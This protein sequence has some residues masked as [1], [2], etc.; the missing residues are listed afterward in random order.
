M[1]KSSS[2]L[3]ISA[4]SSSIALL[5]LTRF[6]IPIFP[7]VH[8]VARYSIIAAIGSIVS[9]AVVLET[10]GRKSVVLSF[11]F[12]LAVVAFLSYL[13]LLPFRG[14]S[15]KS[16]DLVVPFDLAVGVVRITL[17]SG[18]IG[19]TIGVMV[20]MIFKRRMPYNQSLKPTP[21]RGGAA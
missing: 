20:A 8:Y 3:I 9:A 4:V 21:P 6:L 10:S 2:A 12:S 17:F 14:S 13:S 18:S 1:A 11:V 7:G 5:A 15:F 19:F 16:G